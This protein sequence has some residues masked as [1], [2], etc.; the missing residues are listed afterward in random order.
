[1]RPLKLTMSAF[2]PYA[3]TVELN[4]ELLGS[5]GLYLVTGDTG[6]GKTTIF[7][8]ITFAL[9]GEASGNIRE[10]AMLRSKYANAKTPTEVEL[11]FLYS[12][13]TYTV[14]RNPEYMR[15]KER[16]E[17]FTKKAA[18]ACLTLPDGKVITRLKEVN[19]A[20]R[21]I[22][23]LDR[24]QFAQVSMIAQGDFL[25]LLLADTKERQS[26]FRSIFNTH[27]YVQ[28]QNKLK[29]E[30][31][32]VWVQWKDAGQ[33][34]RQY[35]AGIVCSENSVHQEAVDAAKTGEM[36]TAEVLALLD[37]LLA[38]DTGAL[39]AL[40][41]ELTEIE[42]KMEQISAQLIQAE[43]RNRVQNAL[44]A[45]HTQQKQAAAKLA[46]AKEA[47]HAQQALL[48]RQEELRG[49]ITAMQ[50]SLPDYDRLENLAT[51]LTAGER[52]LTQ[53]ESTYTTAT[54]TCESLSAEL[55]QLEAERTE[56][57][58]INSRLERVSAQLTQ[59]ND[60]KVKLQKLFSDIGELE[61]EKLKL[62]KAQNAY[63][64]ASEKATA[65]QQTYLQKN[66][67][68]LNE[69]AGIIAAT[70]VSGAPCPVCGSTSH[71][72]PAALSA[73]APT[74]A[75]VKSAKRLADTA[76][77]EAAN[78]SST[79]SQQMGKV[80]TAEKALLEDITSILG[81]YGIA[82]AQKSAEA[83]ITALNSRLQALN[84]EK[85]ELEQAQKRKKALDT[86]IP[87]KES[88]LAEALKSAGTARE[89]I[90]ALTASMDALRAQR[91]ELSGKLIFESKAAADAEITRLQSDLTQMQKALQQAE[92]DYARCDKE[93]TA[94]NAQ[95]A[96]LAEQLEGIPQIEALSLNEE[97]RELLGRKT[98]LSSRIQS[99]RTGITFNTTARD[100][101]RDKEQELDR[102]D[103]K[104]RWL[105]ALSNT[106]NGQ[107]PG[108][109]K[110][111]L[112]TYIQTTY[113]DRIIARANLRLMKM[114]GGQYN[115]K[116]RKTAL[117]NQSQSG[118]ELDVVDHYNGTERSVKTLSGGESFKASLA[119][120]L[121]LSDEVQMSTGIRLDTLFVDE[122]FGSLDP[123]SLEQAYRTL[124]GLT[125]GNRLVGII[126]HVSE[127]KE[128]IDRQI[129]VTKAK[130]GGSTAR[131]LV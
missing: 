67:A 70:L 114:T 82:D 50:L 108:K 35:M 95:A 28:L 39:E 56:L 124:A 105:R 31:N 13:K 122:G 49:Q 37:D 100:H 32:A 113:F 25:K 20:I 45:C 61:K 6:A 5:S 101:I 94:L 27:L 129:L 93:L 26:I 79:A 66:Q 18:D 73:S 110:I 46:P 77:Q 80:S 112:E 120:A 119:L 36:P 128:K 44:D 57:E 117:N 62:T 71:P 11:T 22:I 97:K 90:A 107:I 60:E 58:S 126:S 53:A 72:S 14:K 2:G 9:Y 115:L 38:E 3:E 40:E 64:A 76:Q 65:L 92:T 91:T 8:A 69:Q 1:M 63:L 99:L 19:T 42:Q 102:I 43:N 87:A 51:Q 106:A 23:G 10:P 41:A 55:Q 85:Q 33:S 75:D 104:M 74:E 78:S 89:C 125:E 118:L 68:F 59:C 52:D 109:E 54:K 16:G 130:S 12:G 121:G 48:P 21:E 131:I 30:A 84:T 24:E 88:A 34:L 96:Q 116:R 15:P 111:M 98:Q 103:E 4:F 29:D 123:E 81:A 17:G 83:A 7:D 86:T 47:L 127:L